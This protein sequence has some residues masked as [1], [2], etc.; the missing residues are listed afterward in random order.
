MRSGLKKLVLEKAAREGRFIRN[1]DISRETKLTENT[2]GKWMNDEDPLKRI[3]VDS[4]MTLATWVPCD[5]RELLIYERVS[6]K[7]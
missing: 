7:S 6:E 1:V 4:L 2:V 5:P 3:E